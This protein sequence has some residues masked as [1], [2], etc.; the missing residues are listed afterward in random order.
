M[1][2]GN[3][4]N[5]VDGEP[6]CGNP[7][8]ILNLPDLASSSQIKK[9][10]KTRSLQLHP[11][12]RKHNLSAKEHGAL[13]QQ[14]IHVQEAKSFLLDAEFEKQKEK[15]D[16]KLKSQS[17]RREEDKKREESMNVWRKNMKFDL[18]EKLNRELQKKNGYQST[19]MNAN[20]N[21]STAAADLDLQKDGKR[22]REEYTAKKYQQEERE[23]KR[24]WKKQ[25][26]DLQYR[27]VRI[28]W[29]RNKMGS[30]SEAMIAHLLSKQFG[31]VE[32]VE[33]IGRK[34][35]AA[36]VTFVNGSSCK[37]CVDAYLTSDQLRATFVGN[38]K[39]EEDDND[40]NDGYNATMKDSLRR[41]R[42][43]ESVEERKLRQE[44]EREKI[45]RQMESGNYDDDDN[46]NVSNTGNGYAMNSN[47]DNRN[48]KSS[49]SNISK[50]NSIFP[51][52]FPPVDDTSNGEQKIISYLERL[53]A[54]EQIILK[55][56]VSP[57]VLK[58]AR[59][60]NPI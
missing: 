45:L 30:Q 55:N 27:Q 19:T 54:L 34:G 26:H 2:T 37:P 17:M 47:Q 59:L 20:A 39:E 10:F 21:I 23:L 29:S 12:K 22:R 36:M 58:A 18:Q 40:D 9:A 41:E 15:Y 49:S 46:C 43:R 31:S 3:N 14:F 35:N 1:A 52:H 56:L 32:Q 4:N 48:E 33:L 6:K 8:S 42:D 13:D 51:P 5:N 7:Y 60:S 53:E 25:K 16:L 50:P 38:R 28:K 57:D 24:E 11:D 44:A